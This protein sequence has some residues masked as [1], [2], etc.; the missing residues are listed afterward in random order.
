MLG[1]PE[2]F[3]RLR[4]CAEGGPFWTLVWTLRWL[5]L[6]VLRCRPAKPPTGLNFRP[7]V[8]FCAGSSDLYSRGGRFWRNSV[9]MSQSVSRHLIDTRVVIETPEGVD[10][11]FR[12]AGPGQRLWAWSIDSLIKAGALAILWMLLLMLGAIGGEAGIQAMA[13][14]ATIGVFVSNWFYGSLF[15]GLMNGQTPGKRAAGLRVLRTNGTPID[16]LT[17]TGRNFLRVA[18]ALPLGYTVGLITMLLT[19][20]LQRLGDLFFDTMVVSEQRSPT[21]RAAGLTK[22]I[23]PL[24]RSECPRK[25]SVP[26]RTLATIERLFD[27]E[28]IMSEGRREEIARPLSEALRSR[29][30]WSEPWKTEGNQY[31]FFQQQGYR[32]TQFLL[33]VLKTFAVEAETGG[34]R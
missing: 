29:L 22:S 32:H 21:G 14:V 7:F 4:E 31:E 6:E 23:E 34:Q 33:R 17:A 11:R 24:A 9:C 8:S 27:P 13:G 3:P 10:F 2:L 16:L 25:F 28:R 19:P 12:I 26:E 1:L 30:G 5:W 15:E 20:K 18:D